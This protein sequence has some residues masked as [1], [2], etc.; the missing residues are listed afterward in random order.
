MAQR[1]QSEDQQVVGTA[2]H[3]CETDLVGTGRDAGF[4]GEFADHG[5]SPVLAV[6]DEPAGQCEQSALRRDGAPDDE[7]AGPA[8]VP[9]G[10]ESDGDG[11]RVAVV[12]RAASGARAGIAGAR[13]ER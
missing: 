7:Q 6:V 1:Q 8:R 5:A 11:Q 10:E 4:L 9:H 3:I 12:R 2:Q 13:C